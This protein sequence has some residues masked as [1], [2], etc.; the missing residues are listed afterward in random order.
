MSINQL[1]NWSGFH[2][3]ANSPAE[4]SFHFT[5]QYNFPF[6]KG[7]NTQICRLVFLMAFILRK[8]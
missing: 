8:P 1:T 4:E 2:G 3:K 6:A 7:P 5:P